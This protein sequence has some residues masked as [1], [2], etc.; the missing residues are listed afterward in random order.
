MAATA[1]CSRRLQKT[2]NQKAK[3]RAAQ[4]PVNIN[5][6]DSSV[7][8]STSSTSAT[9][10]GDESQATTNK[11]ARPPLSGKAFPF[12]RPEVDLSAMLSVEQM[13]QLQVLMIA[14]MDEIQTQVRDNFDQMTITP[15]EPTEGITAPRAIVLSVPNPGSDKYRSQYGNI[16]IPIDRPDFEDRDLLLQIM[17]S[18]PADQH[19]AKTKPVLTIPKSHDEATASSKKSEIE[20]A[21]AS[22]TELKRD[23]LGH[24]GKWRGL[25]FKRL[26][27]VVIK[28]GG[29][30]GNAV[31]QGPH[32][33][34]RVGSTAGGSAA[35]PSGKFFLHSGLRYRP[36][37]RAN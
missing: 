11:M 15:V 27:E 16:G 12:K 1:G 34:R 5:I 33:A 3:M 32:N 8:I 23:A 2:R 31:R 7:G 24:F 18:H 36:M 26:Q 20:I 22:L 13:K 10:S 28:N 25:V 21:M 37:W 17:K 30:A 6:S 35:R 29:T 14:I 4:A 9:S 19:T